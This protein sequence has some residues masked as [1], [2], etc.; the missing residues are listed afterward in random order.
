MQNAYQTINEEGLIVS[1]T[2]QAKDLRAIEAVNSLGISTVILNSNDSK[3]INE[4]H[5]KNP[6]SV[7][8]ISCLKHEETFDYTNHHA[9]FVL[10]PC[11]DLTNASAY[12]FNG[13]RVIPY[14]ETE[15][16]VERLKDNYSTFMI[17]FNT[18]IEQKYPNHFFIINTVSDSD[19]KETGYL[20]NVLAYVVHDNMCLMDNCRSIRRAI[21]ALLDVS[22]AHVGLNSE[23][24]QDADEMTTA[25][26]KLFIQ[27]RE[28]TF[29]SYFGSEYSEVM[30][31]ENKRG[32]HGHIGVAVNNVPRAMHYYEAM[33][34]HFNPDSVQVDEFGNMTLIYMIEQIGG[35]ALHLYRK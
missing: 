9:D 26:S 29:V 11:W 34:Y 10:L 35:F 3:L 6:D 15:N 21:R 33:G 25:F 31:P 27:E 18:G 14:C 24:E 5:Q 19:I 32:I 28:E 20:T 23:N 12:L 13:I 30:K 7:I 8:G 4:I 2:S 22:L 17:N 16:D 1:F